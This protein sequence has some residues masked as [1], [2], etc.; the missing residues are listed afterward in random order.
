M[1]RKAMDKILS[2]TP[3]LFKER[4]NGKNRLVKFDGKDIIY[5]NAVLFRRAKRRANTRDFIGYGA[6]SNQIN[7]I[8]IALMFNHLSMFIIYRTGAGLLTKNGFE[9]RRNYAF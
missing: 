6:W 8:E 5:K 4:I 1:D 7:N 2:G 3:C 9:D